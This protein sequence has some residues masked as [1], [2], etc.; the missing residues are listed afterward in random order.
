M[1]DREIIPKLRERNPA[2]NRR[3]IWGERG[4]T[5][6]VHAI[7][8]TGTRDRYTDKT[9]PPA[10]VPDTTNQKPTALIVVKSTGKP[11]RD[12]S[13]WKARYNHD[14]LAIAHLLRSK[15]ETHST[16]SSTESNDV[17]MLKSAA[18]GASYG[19]EIPVK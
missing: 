15:S 10:L 19:S 3:V 5:P 18:S 12:Q 8:L 2:E 7:S 9:M 17:S 1:E 14:N 11:S 4:V 6:H 16:S 13:L